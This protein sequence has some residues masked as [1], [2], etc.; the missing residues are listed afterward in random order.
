MSELHRTPKEY[1]ELHAEQYCNGDIE[2]A[3]GQA[4]VKAVLPT[5][6]EE[7]E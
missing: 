3:A 5:L 6:E 2:V 7:K 4:I 1:T